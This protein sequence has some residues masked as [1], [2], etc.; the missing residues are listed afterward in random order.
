MQNCKKFKKKM[1]KTIIVQFLLSFLSCQCIIGKV[2]NDEYVETL[3]HVEMDETLFDEEKEYLATALNHVDVTSAGEVVG[4]PS[5]NLP[6]FLIELEFPDSKQEIDENVASCKSSVPT[7]EGH[8]KQF[9]ELDVNLKK[10]AA[11]MNKDWTKFLAINQ[12]TDN[13]NKSIPVLIGALKDIKLYEERLSNSAVKRS[14]T[15]LQAEIDYQVELSINGAKDFVSSMAIVNMIWPNIPFDPECANKDVVLI[16][17]I[18]YIKNGIDKATELTSTIAGLIQKA[19]QK[20][21][22][23]RGKLLSSTVF[24]KAHLIWDHIYMSDMS[25]GVK[26]TVLFGLNEFYS[27]KKTATMSQLDKQITSLTSSVLPMVIKSFKCKY[28]RK[29]FLTKLEN[30]CTN[31]EDNFETIFQEDHTRSIENCIDDEKIYKTRVK[32]MVDQLMISQG[33]DTKCVFNSEEKRNQACAFERNGKLTLEISQILHLSFEN[34]EYYLRFCNQ[35]N[36]PLPNGKDAICFSKMQLTLPSKVIEAYENW[37][38][39]QVRDIYH[40]CALDKSQIDSIC[41]NRSK[42]ES[43]Q[44]IHKTLLVY[45]T[46]EV[47]KAYEGCILFKEVTDND[48]SV[49]CALKSKNVLITD[50][51]F[52]VYKS[53]YSTALFKQTYDECGKARDIKLKV[54]LS[55]KRTTKLLNDA[56]RRIRKWKFATN[57]YG[58]F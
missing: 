25:P 20:Y 37:N 15:L 41:Q 8:V 40:K 1:K 29:A 56:M 43:F 39:T 16:D 18:G 33:K 4:E 27:N 32:E 10:Q 5:P 38:T 54:E 48:I 46:E 49:I 36:V 47:R 9:R 6:N 17:C 58:I 13:L 21:E 50:S 35:V 22:E 34:V 3:S 2:Y 26:A 19:E 51:S 11:A 7:F 14:M 30:D 24:E 55:G 28:D 23:I 57:G 52:N 31:G 45:T 44:A 53:K 12:Y 42:S